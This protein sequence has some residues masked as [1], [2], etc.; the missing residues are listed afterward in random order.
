[1]VHLKSKDLWKAPVRLAERKGKWICG[2]RNMK[3]SQAYPDEFGLAILMDLKQ[4]CLITAMVNLIKRPVTTKL[5]K[6]KRDV[7]DWMFKTNSD[8]YVPD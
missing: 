5:A 3:P 4:P 8:F 1:M 7:E 2:N 6:Q